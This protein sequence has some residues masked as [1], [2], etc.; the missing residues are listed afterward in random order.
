MAEIGGF[1]DP[2]SAVSEDKTAE[3]LYS[4]TRPLDT[5]T[6]GELTTFKPCPVQKGTGEDEFLKEKEWGKEADMSHK[7]S[8]STK[9]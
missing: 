8:H 9:A 5:L 6:R 3:A 1:P 2:S 4:R 7:G